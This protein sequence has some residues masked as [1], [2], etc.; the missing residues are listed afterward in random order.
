MKHTVKTLVFALFVA[1]S[2]VTYASD[3]QVKKLTGPQI[4]FLN[5]TLQKMPFVT[6]RLELARKQALQ[7]LKNLEQANAQAGLNDRALID[8]H[9]AKVLSPLQEFF[10]QVKE[11]DALVRKL[12]QDIFEVTDTE[13]NAFYIIKFLNS[14]ATDLLQFFKKT[15][16]D[17]AELKT[18]L[19]EFNVFLSTLNESFSQEVRDALITFLKSLKEKN[20]DGQ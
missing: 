16:K 7:S 20:H 12:V 18:V 3:N 5:I 11:H 17:K 14:D 2:A 4:N 8:T 9:V 19:Q 10:N 13:V 15:I 6:A 1:F